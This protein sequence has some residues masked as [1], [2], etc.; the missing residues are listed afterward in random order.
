MLS[1]ANVWPTTILLL[2]YKITDAFNFGFSQL[3]C[4]FSSAN[5]PEVSFAIILSLPVAGLLLTWLSHFV[6]KI[7][8]CESTTI[9]SSSCKRVSLQILLFSYFPIT[10]KTFAAVSP[11]E[12]RDGLSYMKDTPWL[13]CHGSSYNWLLALGYLSLV[14][15][16]FGVPLFIF[17]PLLYRYLNND[18]QAISQDT[19]AW[20]KPLYQAFKQSYHRYFPLVFLLRRLLLAVFLTLVPTN[21]S[22]QVLGITLLLVICIII[23]LV[24]RP[25]EQYSAKFEFEVMADVTV[26]VVLLL[27]F[28]WFGA[29]A[30]FSEI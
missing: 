13:D 25:Y 30:S 10:A 11:C 15:F 1:D 23:V 6:G 16:V 22:Y 4:S 29:V 28:G 27:S 14:V 19:H 2:R 5:R 12:H 24:F 18:G 17:A 8:C 21:S 3:S 26:S 9:S 20:L 7:L